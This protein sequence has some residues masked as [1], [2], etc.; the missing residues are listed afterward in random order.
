QGEQGAELSP[1]VLVARRAK[2]EGSARWREARSKRLRQ[3]LGGRDV[4]GAVDDQPWVFAEDLDPR[5]ELEAR[6]PADHG[7]AVDGQS[8][9]GEDVEGRQGDSR[10]VGLVRTEEGKI[11]RPPVAPPGLHA[12]SARLGT[13]EGSRGG[14][15]LVVEVVSECAQGRA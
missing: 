6:E 12:G 9:F 8:L 5:R 13:D 2:D 3:C 14:E 15:V 11:E 4:V 7:G 10:V 1:Q